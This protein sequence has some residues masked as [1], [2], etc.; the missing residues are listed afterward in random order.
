M[1]DPVELRDV[2]DPAFL[3]Y[4]D[5]RCG[6]GPIQPEAQ[7]YDPNAVARTDAELACQ[8]RLAQARRLKRLYA[9]W[10]AGQN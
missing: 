8:Y 4:L 9:E 5:H 3:E 1:P 6:E 10:K 2:C 7:D